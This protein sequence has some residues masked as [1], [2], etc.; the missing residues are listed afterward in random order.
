[1]LALGDG[2][3]REAV[4]EVTKESVSAVESADL[5]AECLESDLVRSAPVKKFIELIGAS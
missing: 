4:T 5:Y 1:M 3:A 2:S